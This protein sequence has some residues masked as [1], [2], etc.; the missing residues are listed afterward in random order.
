MSRKHLKETF[1]NQLINYLNELSLMFPEEQDIK[2]YTKYLNVI[3]KLTPNLIY[4]FFDSNISQFRPY[5][6]NR[7]E[8][9]FMGLD[10]GENVGGNEKS[11]M[12]AIHF[13]KLWSLMDENSKENTWQQFELLFLLL[14]KIVETGQKK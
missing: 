8:T 1:N 4:K 6:E 13:T 11:M 9:F 2:T 5:C 14:D 12:K 10:Y 3:N 7:D